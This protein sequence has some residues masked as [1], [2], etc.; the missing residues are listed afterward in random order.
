MRGYAKYSIQLVQYK[1]ENWVW[2]GLEFGASLTLQW[3]SGPPLVRRL[4]S[5]V[6]C[7]RAGQP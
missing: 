4:T 2:L 3:V 1:Y 7:S 6:N 5:S